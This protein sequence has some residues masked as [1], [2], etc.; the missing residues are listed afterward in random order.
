[1]EER[2]FRTEFR[3]LT[4]RYGEESYPPEV[5]TFFWSRVKNMT[6]HWWS[7][8][9]TTL[10]ASNA[11]APLWDKFEVHFIAERNRGGLGFDSN[12]PRYGSCGSC[13]DGIL[14]AERLDMLAAPYAFIC[15]CRAGDS[16]PRKYPK[17]T[18]ESYNSFRPLNGK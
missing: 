15:D 13:D 16:N 5:W 3:R 9:V 6:T 12:E 18:N 11:R 4:A 10:I 14:M 8:T 1:M 7:Q 17:W 2:D